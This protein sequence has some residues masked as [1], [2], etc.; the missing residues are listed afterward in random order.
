M[1]RSLLFLPGAGADHTFWDPVGNLLPQDWDKAY[2]GWPG[3]GH[4]RP[5]PEVN[6]FEDLVRFAERRLTR[7]KTTVVAQSFGGAVA[8]ALALRHPKRVESLVLSTTAAGLDS[9]PF[10]VEDWRPAYRAEYHD[11]AAWL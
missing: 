1:G 6:G 4:N 8:L 10:G 2:L 3:L 7:G 11:A 5:D 9:S